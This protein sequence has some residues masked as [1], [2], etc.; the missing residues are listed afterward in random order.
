MS[1]PPSRIYITSPINNPLVL[2]IQT[3]LNSINPRAF[4]LNPPNNSN[5]E[6]LKIFHSVI[7]TL[8][9]MEFSTPTS[10][11][12]PISIQNQT[13]LDSQKLVIVHLYNH[14]TFLLSKDWIP[15]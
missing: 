14:L 11:F 1:R 6:A 10:S 2:S 4:S 12:A 8:S 5:K 13:L 15:Y 3:C 7:Q 9:Q